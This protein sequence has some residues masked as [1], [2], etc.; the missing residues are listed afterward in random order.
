MFL[1]LEKFNLQSSKPC[2]DFSMG[3]TQNFEP[4]FTHKISQLSE[5]LPNEYK[6]RFCLYYS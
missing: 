1:I 2:V 5:S 3:K 6:D 4:G